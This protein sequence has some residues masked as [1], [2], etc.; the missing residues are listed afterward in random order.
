M[1]IRVSAIIVFFILLTVLLLQPLTSLHAKTIRLRPVTS[2]YADALGAPLKLPEGVACCHRQSFIIVADTGNARL[3]KVVFH[4]PNMEKD[5]SEIRVPQITYPMKTMFDSKDQIYILDGKQRRII[6][7]SAQ[8]KFEG[9]FE[10]KDVPSPSAYVLRSFTIDAKDNVLVLD[11]LSA[12][13]LVLDPGGTFQRQVKFPKKYGFFSDLAVDGKGRV[14]I[15]DGVDAKVYATDR[16]TEKFISLTGNLKKYMRFPSHLTTDA[17]G[18]IYLTDRNGGSIII[19]GSDGSFI[20]RQSGM[21]WNEGF[22]RYPSQICINEKGQVFVADTM[23][24][25]I[26]IFSIQD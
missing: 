8:G 13:V 5:S 21:G 19:L 4:G 25:R 23:N 7:L 17:R 6:R 22:M 20:G 18:R 3:L 15:L 16:G 1:G 9:Y 24:N 11:I 12:R 26:Q 10:P 14:L 2:I